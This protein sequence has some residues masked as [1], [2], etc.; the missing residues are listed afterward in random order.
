MGILLEYT[1]S[2]ILSTEGDYKGLGQQTLILLMLHYERKSES[3]AIDTKTPCMT[4]L[5]WYSR[6][7]QSRRIF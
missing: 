7:L 5:L 3:G 6:R 4:G 1:Q 2:H